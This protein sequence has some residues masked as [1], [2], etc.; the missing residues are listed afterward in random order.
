MPKIIIFGRLFQYFMQINISAAFVR[1]EL[2]PNKRFSSQLEKEKRKAS[3]YKN[4][5]RFLEE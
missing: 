3:I 5:I 4:H 1:E 2:P